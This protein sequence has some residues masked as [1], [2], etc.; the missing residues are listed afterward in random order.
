MDTIIS[1]INRE[2]IRTIWH[3]FNLEL[4]LPVIDKQ[5]LYLISI[6]I[7]LEEALESQP[8]EAD[9]NRA[10]TETMSHLMDFTVAHFGTEERLLEHFGYDQSTKHKRAHTG[11][12]GMLKKRSRERFS[13]STSEAAMALVRDL[14]HWLFKHILADDRAYIDFLR[15]HTDEAN[16]FLEKENDSFLGAR[17][18]LNLLYAEVRAHGIEEKTPDD[19]I[20]RAVSDI[21]HRYNLKTGIAIVDLQ[22]LWLIKLLME[23]ERLYRQRLTGAINDN[24]VALRFTDCLLAAIDYIR[25]H[26]ATEEAV[27]R[28]FNFPAAPTHTAQHKYF[29]E[30]VAGAMHANKG[31]PDLKTINDLINNLKEWLIGHIAVEDKKLFFFFRNKLGDVNDYVKELFRE[32]KLHVWKDAAVLYKTVAKFELS[33]EP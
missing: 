30:F 23:M 16:A 32:G 25:E 21:W 24:Q 7:H 20:L 2:R 22:H 11:F 14:K 19:E 28:K 9:L 12:V 13:R 6:L 17:D 18:D 5:H 29:T 26:F 4:G 33:D 8:S 15:E 31:A 3:R 10:Y 27:M 1:S